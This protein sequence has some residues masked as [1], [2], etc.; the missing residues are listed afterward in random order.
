MTNLFIV[1]DSLTALITSSYR[2]CIV[3]KATAEEAFGSEE[4]WNAKGL[5]QTVANLF[6]GLGRLKVRRK[7]KG[8]FSCSVRVWC[9]FTLQMT[10]NTRYTHTHI[11]VVQTD[12]FFHIGFGVRTPFPSFTHTYQMWCDQILLYVLMCVCVCVAVAVLL[13]CE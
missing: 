12:H 11:C 8:V 3:G 5:R 2:T 4:G 13:K 1:G 9:L 7:P 6:Q 10:H